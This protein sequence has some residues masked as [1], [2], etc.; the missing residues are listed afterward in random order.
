MLRL[1]TQMMQIQSNQNISQEYSIYFPNNLKIQITL[2]LPN[3]EFAKI[4]HLDNLRSSQF[5]Y[6]DQFFNLDEVYAPCT[7]FSGSSFNEIKAHLIAMLS[8]TSRLAPVM[9]V[10]IEF[11][12]G[13]FREWLIEKFKKIGRITTKQQFLQLS[14]ISESDTKQNMPILFKRLRN[15]QSLGTPLNLQCGYQWIPFKFEKEQSWNTQ[16]TSRFI[17][18]WPHTVWFVVEDCTENMF[19]GLKNRPIVIIDKELGI[20]ITLD[21]K[22]DNSLIIPGVFE[23]DLNRVIKAMAAMHTL[24]ISTY[25]MPQLDF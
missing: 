16:D 3:L 17:V 24:Y 12:Q 2:E 15:I 13:L 23:V 25:N 14:D 22:N 21:P 18:Y 8:Q 19:S 4:T 11:Y 6:P 20:A 7:K 10:I 5:W 9:P 1:T